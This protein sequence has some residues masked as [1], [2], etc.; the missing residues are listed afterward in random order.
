MALRFFKNPIAK[1]RFLRFKEMKHAY[2][3]L[4]ILVSLYLLS[5]C[6]EVICNNLPLYVK[7]EGNSYFP[8]FKFYPED[9]FTKIEN[10]PK[11]K[12][13]NKKKKIIL[14][15]LVGKVRS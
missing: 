6:S 8:I 4:W 14:C 9:V 1:K 12:S 2:I 10:D 13:K 5:L 15:N 7:F 3:S 11:I